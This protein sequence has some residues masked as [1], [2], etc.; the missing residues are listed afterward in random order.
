MFLDFLVV[1]V[2]L[3]LGHSG[4]PSALATGNLLYGFYTQSRNGSYENICNSERL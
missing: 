4:E 3:L 2:H 1:N